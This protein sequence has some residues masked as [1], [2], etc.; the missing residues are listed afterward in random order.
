MVES[1][2]KFLHN[3]ANFKGRSTR[4]DYWWVVLANFLIGFFLGFLG[5]FF[6]EDVMKI[7]TLIASIYELAILIP[8][9]AI[10]VRRFHDI[11]KSGWFILL[12]LIP[13]VGGL[14]VFI[15][16]VLPSV[17]ENNQYGEVVQ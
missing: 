2:K 17:N 9:L 8:G 13:F 15:F 6:G 7:T 10:T 5:G 12:A 11:N 4:A 14:I 16:T 3:Y 1:Y